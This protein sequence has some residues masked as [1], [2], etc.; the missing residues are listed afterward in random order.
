MNFVVFYYV[1]FAKQEQLSNHLANYSDVLSKNNTFLTSE[2]NE[3]GTSRLMSLYSQAAKTSKIQDI[4]DAF[5]N[6]TFFNLGFIFLFKKAKQ[7]F[8][9]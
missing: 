5:L 4:N 7:E 3:I 1:Y 6:V 8:N 9:K 2:L